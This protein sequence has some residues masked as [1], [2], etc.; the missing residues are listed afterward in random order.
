MSNRVLTV[1]A[2]NCT[3]CHMC[4]LACSSYKEGIFIPHRSRIWVVTNGLEGWS[5]PAICLHCEDPACL[6]ACEVGAIYKTKTP[7]GDTIIIIDPEE[8]TG[9]KQCVEACPF[10]AIA[11]FDEFGIIK[12]DLCGGAPKCVDFCAYNCL[13]FVDL[14][15]DA[16]Q[17]RSKKITEIVEQASKE[18]K[19]QDLHQRRVKYSLEM[20]NINS[21]VIDIKKK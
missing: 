13:N 7:N 20:A 6:N 16:Y 5:R 19:K 12:C 1:Q 10:G 11:F 21:P 14:A 8:C 15:E 18:N 17:E 4:E 2:E 9:C 3:G